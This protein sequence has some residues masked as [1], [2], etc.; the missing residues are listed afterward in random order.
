MRTRFVNLRIPSGG[1]ETAP[2]E[3]VVENGRFAGVSP[4]GHETAAEGE[5]WIDLGGALVLPGAIDGHVH[6]DDPGFTHREDFASGTTAAAAGGVTC[7]VDMP[8]TS[9][10]P[11]TDATSLE[12][13]LRAVSAKAHVDFML[14]GGVSANAMAASD[15][16]RRLD[17]LADA[18]VAA[19]KVYTLSGMETFHHLNSSQLV[20]VLVRTRRLGLPVGVHAEDPDM[21]GA[22][23]ES[24]Q[25]Q[26]QDSP[27]AYA[28]SRPAAAEVAAVSAAIEACRSTGA[29][30]HIVHLGSGEALDLIE[31]ARR[32][33]GCPS[34]PRPVP[35]SSSSPVPTSSAWV[36]SSRPPRS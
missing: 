12:V 30:V 32:R 28:D 24:L 19:I 20:E 23:T 29:R 13:K 35:T 7:V 3:L 36:R 9:L 11:V 8:C 10:P 34:P 1:N 21:V 17:G 15:W 16:G 22:L 27:S 4:A 18:G 2:S 26:G 25:D 5:D 6:F 14:W 33:A 31:E